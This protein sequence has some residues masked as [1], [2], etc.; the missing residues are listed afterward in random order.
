[1]RN[2]TISWRYTSIIIGLLLLF[3]LYKITSDF[4]LS[5]TNP[6]LNKTAYIY[7]QSNQS[8]DRLIFNLQKDNLLDN[9]ESFERVAKLLN[10]DKNIKPG[11]YKIIPRLSNIQLIRILKLGRQEPVNLIINYARRKSNLAATISKQIELDSNKLMALMCDSIVLQKVNMDSNNIISLFIPNT[12]NM[13]WNINSTRFMERMFKEYNS[14]W[15]SSRTTKSILLKMS[16]L[17]VATLA[18]I[19]MSETNKVDEMPIIART[20]LNRLKIGMPL[21]AD[22]TIIFA[23]NDTAVKR[24]LSIHTAINNPYNTYLNKGLPPGPICMSSPTAIDAVLNAPNHNYIYFCA[25]EDFSGY[26]NFAE[27]FSQHQ[28]NARKYQNELNRRGY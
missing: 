14:F 4:F 12:Y 27:T 1:M 24:V 22:P 2:Y 3:A 16:P 17:Q 7:I 6:D 20:Y 26:H 5:N 8:F 18:S 9:V 28:I 23:L 19:V 15:N 11:R 10:L 21:Q 13:Y 25:K